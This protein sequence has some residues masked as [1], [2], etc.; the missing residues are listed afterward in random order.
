[1]MD[2]TTETANWVT[3]VFG[4]PL[5]AVFHPI[6]SMLDPIYMPWARVCAL[7]LFIGAMIWV[8]M[9]RREYVD[10]ERPNN[11][12]YTDLRIWTVVAMLPHVVI[13]LFL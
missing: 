9:L 10:I 6:D 13:Y 2:E 3:R 1:M 8:W 7:G 4:P 5:K 12:W 11:K